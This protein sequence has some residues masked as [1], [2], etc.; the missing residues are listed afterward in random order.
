M[1]DRNGEE[2]VQIEVIYQT[3]S[4]FLQ[5]TPPNQWRH[6]YCHRKFGPPSKPRL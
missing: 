5:S 1:I 3:F 6:M 2:Q 4:E